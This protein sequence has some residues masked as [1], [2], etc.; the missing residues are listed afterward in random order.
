MEQSLLVKREYSGGTDTHAMI[1]MKSSVVYVGQQEGAMKEPMMEVGTTHPPIAVTTT[2]QYNK[3][4]YTATT[5]RT[6]WLK[7]WDDIDITIL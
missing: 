5:P 2:P 3:V 4:I 1:K 7:G 6:T